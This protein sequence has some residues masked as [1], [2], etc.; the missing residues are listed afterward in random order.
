MAQTVDDL[1]KI[2]I[3]LFSEMTDDEVK[4]RIEQEEIAYLARQA[5]LKGS[6]PLEDYFDVLEAVEVDMDD[7]VTTLESGLVVV[8]VL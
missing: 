5:F 6:I 1:I 7:Y 3:P 4:L 2:E 8:G